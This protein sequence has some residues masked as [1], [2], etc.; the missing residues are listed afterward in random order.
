MSHLGGLQAPSWYSNHINLK[1][2]F[3]EFSSYKLANLYIYRIFITYTT[4]INIVNFSQSAICIFPLDQWLVFSSSRNKPIMLA[5]YLQEIIHQ[6]GLKSGDRSSTST[7]SNH[8]TKHVFEFNLPKSFINFNLYKITKCIT[9][10]NLNQEEN[11]LHL[12]PTS[13]SHICMHHAIPK[14]L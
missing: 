7:D 8:L 10:S 11:A 1:V 9:P 13:H 12:H 4:P 5:S 6:H 2:V 3:V 14:T